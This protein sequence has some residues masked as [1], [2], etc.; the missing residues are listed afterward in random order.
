[1]HAYYLT[2]EPDF[3]A[4]V[5][6]L[7]DWVVAMDD[8][9]RNI[10]G[11]I[12]AEPTGLASVFG[13]PHSAGPGR[14]AANSIAVLVD[15]WR[16]SGDLTYLAKAEALIRRCIHPADDIESREL[17]NIEQR[18]SY[19][20]FLS[21]LSGYLHAKHEFEQSDEMYAYA[22]ASLLHY[23]RWM[24]HH[25]R[26]YFDQADQMQFPTEAWAAQE[27]R[28]AN[29]LRL[30]ASHADGE[31]CESFLQRAASLADRAWVDLM[32][33]ESRLSARAVAIVLTEGVR[34]LFFRSEIPPP[35]PEAAVSPDFAAPQP[36]CS[37]R[38]VAR[39]RLNTIGGLALVARDLI[40]PTNWLKATFRL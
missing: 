33:F 20:M 5:L 10:L 30:A 3:R 40:N 24:L 28:K 32:R 1:L 27:F 15:A 9:A 19:T 36:F 6:E 12:S 31:L 8:G 17:L 18:W 22:R 23:S 26:P 14:G 37:Q 34:D 16:L 29:V 38:T 25:E 4:A 7:A 2:G 39:R 35:L 21:S 11:M 13:G